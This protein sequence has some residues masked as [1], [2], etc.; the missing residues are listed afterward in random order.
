MHKDWC[1]KPCSECV[2]PC[3]L[4]C[5]MPCSP[6]CEHL[7]KNG[8]HMHKECQCCDS[9][10]LYRIPIRYSG[11]VYIRAGSPEEAREIID[12]KDVDKMYEES[13]GSWDIFQPEEE[14]E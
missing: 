8:E 2:N 4:D 14:I 12:E 13:A 9:L 1:G 11:A 7:G 6:D 10:P 3:E 5:S